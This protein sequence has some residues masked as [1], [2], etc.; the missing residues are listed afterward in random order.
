M[1]GPATCRI[2]GPAD[3]LANA[4][5]GCGVVCVG[6]KS[7]EGGHTAVLVQHGMESRKVIR[8]VADDLAHIVD[9]KGSAVGSAA[10]AKFGDGIAGKQ[11]AVLERF[12]AGAEE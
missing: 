2:V 7:A 8:R 10:S 3:D 6:A 1:L 5:A 12:Y 9:A 4:V 11:R